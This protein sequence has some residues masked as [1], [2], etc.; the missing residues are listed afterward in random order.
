M[1]KYLDTQRFYGL[2]D[3]KDSF[4]NAAMIYFKCHKK[5][6]SINSIVDFIVV[7]TA[8]ENNLFLLHNDIDFKKI[9]EVIS[10]KFF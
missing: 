3:E 4:A 8:I 9:S 2:I 6:I 10:I 7:Q 5:G 1:L